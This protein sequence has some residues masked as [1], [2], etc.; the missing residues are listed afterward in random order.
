MCLFLGSLFCSIDLCLCL[1]LC[2]AI[3]ITV[4]LLYSLESQSGIPPALFFF[5]KT[6]LAIWGLLGSHISFRTIY[7]SSVK[8]GLGILIG[9]ALNL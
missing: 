5:L 1:C 3:L 2:H 6:A 4:V 7:S 8:K 9:I